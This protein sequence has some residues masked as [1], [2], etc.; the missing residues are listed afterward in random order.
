[1]NQ[2]EIKIKRLAEEH[3]FLSKEITIEERDMIKASKYAQLIREE[4]VVQKRRGSVDSIMENVLN[5][6]YEKKPKERPKT[7]LNHFNASLD[8]DQVQILCDEIEDHFNLTLDKNPFRFMHLDVEKLK[9]FIRKTA[10]SVI[11]DETTLHE[12]NKLINNPKIDSEKILYTL[13]L[14]AGA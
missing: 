8:R 11:K 14:L 5:G 9:D 12:I 4:L 10:N 7:S 13:Y 2:Q 3:C 1:M 6:T